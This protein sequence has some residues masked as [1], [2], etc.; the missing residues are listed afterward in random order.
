MSVEPAAVRPENPAGSPADVLESLARSC[1]LLGF[2]MSCDPRT[3][4]L[5]RTLAAA[6]P[7]GRILELGT[8]AGMSTAWLLDGMAADSTL[9]TVES[10]SPLVEVARLHL[11]HDPRVRFVHG[12]AGALIERL[13]GDRF[14]LV[15]ADTWAGKFERLDETL[16]LLAPGALYVVDDLLPQPSWPAGH[17]PKAEALAERLMSDGRLRATRLDW[18]S[19]LIVAARI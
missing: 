14:D 9:L 18:S 12:D 4:A 1:A 8:G 2:D 15:F 17:G 5:L 19:G 7:G 13:E 16:E 11:G 10:E 6:R 3:G